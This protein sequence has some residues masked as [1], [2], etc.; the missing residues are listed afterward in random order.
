MEMTEIDSL[1]FKGWTP[2]QVYTSR[3]TKI[4]QILTA[5]NPSIDTFRYKPASHNSLVPSTY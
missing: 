4:A 2:V 3:N 5:L 1:C